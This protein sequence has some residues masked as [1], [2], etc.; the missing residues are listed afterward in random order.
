MTS[1]LDTVEAVDAAD[2]LVLVIVLVVVD[3]RMQA[4]SNRVAPST[5]AVQ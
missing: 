4:P 5:H 2:I 1:D 3:G